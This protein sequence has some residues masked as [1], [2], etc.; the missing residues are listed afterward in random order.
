M[1]KSTLRKSQGVILPLVGLALAVLLGFGGLVIDLGG[2][3]VAKTELQSALD[4]CALAAVKE[5]D[6]ASDALVRATN[7][8]LTAGNANKVQ[9]QKSSSGIVGGE[10]TF[11]NTLTGAYS[12]NF[13]PVAA[14]RYAKCAHT[15]DGIAAYLIQ[16]VGAASTNSVGA[17]AI[18]STVPGQE[19]CHTLP[20]CLKELGV[21]PYKIGQWVTMLYDPN[22]TVPSEMG[23]CNLDGSTNAAETK[24]EVLHGYCQANI[25]DTVGTPGAKV[26]VNDEWNSRFGIYKNNGDVAA[27]PPDRTGYVYTSTNWTNPEPQNAYK[28]TPAAGSHPT[29][30]NFESKRSDHANYADTGTTVKAGDDITGLNMK[31]GGFKSLATSGPF[32][33]HALSNRDMRLITTPVISSS[34]TIVGYACM[35][36]LQPVSNSTISVQLEYLG[37]ADAIDNPCPPSNGMPGG[38]AGNPPVPALV[39]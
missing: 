1:F 31:P 36:M 2:L 29:A 6:G 39:R 9:Y 13:A 3:F 8:G 12:A 38:N 18:A 16:L 20:V 10:V 11:S 15:T 21:A 33:E 5:L 7:A 26:A 23:W 34:N 32:G 28:G 37:A 14:A 22:G 24:D 25:G 27:W 30:A 4:S 19:V 35:L 17:L